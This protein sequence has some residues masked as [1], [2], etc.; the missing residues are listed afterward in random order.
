[1]L[2]DAEKEVRIRGFAGAFAAYALENGVWGGAVIHH[3]LT[4]NE[5]DRGL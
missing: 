5:I 3:I 4:A 2:S 1:M